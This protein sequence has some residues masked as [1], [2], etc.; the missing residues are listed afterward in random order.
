[1]GDYFISHYGA[2]NQMMKLKEECCELICSIVN[3]ESQIKKLKNDYPNLSNDEL[4]EMGVKDKLK[5]N[6]LEEMADCSVVIEQFEGWE[7]N[8][9]IYCIKCEKRN[10][11][12]TRIAKARRDKERLDA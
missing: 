12:L 11:Q 8:G 10:R 9:T 3:I 7:S 5:D 1:M 2:F 6:F 4:F